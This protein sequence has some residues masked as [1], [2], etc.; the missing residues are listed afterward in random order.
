MLN[1]LHKS[2][3]KN[4]SLLSDRQQRMYDFL[5]STPVGVLSTVSPGDDPHG[6]VIY[7]DIDKQFRIVFL[8]RSHTRKHDNIIHNN[9]VMLTVFD[10]KTQTV[11]QVMGRAYELQ[12]SYDINGV[13]GQVFGHTR[14][15]NKVGLMPVN[16]LEAGPYIAFKIDPVQIRMAVYARPDPGDYENIFESIESFDLHQ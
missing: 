14:K 15:I 2:I 8:T 5:K 10:A 9:H 4:K 12:D 11:A 16:K 1:T 7:F 3:R 6:V 13:A